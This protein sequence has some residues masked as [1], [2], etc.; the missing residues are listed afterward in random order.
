L[1]NEHIAAFL[2]SCPRPFVVLLV[3]IPLSGKDTFLKSLLNLDYVEISTDKILLQMAN[4]DDY[5]KAYSNIDSKLIK[6]EVNRQLIYYSALN[7]NVIAN[8]TNLKTKRRKATLSHFNGDFYK[9]AIVFPLIS[10]DEF[11]S[12]NE[13]RF[14]EQKKSISIKLYDEMLDLFEQVNIMDGFNSILHLDKY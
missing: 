4:T 14:K 9:V 12:R 6:K 7:N 10:R 5:R 3:G 11:V 13:K 8:M 2:I 1:N